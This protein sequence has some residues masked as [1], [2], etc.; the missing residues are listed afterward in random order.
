MK[1]YLNFFFSSFRH[2]VREIQRTQTVKILSNIKIMFCVSL[3][4]LDSPCHFQEKQKQTQVRQVPS[5]LSY[6]I[7]CNVFF[8]PKHLR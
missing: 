5:K 6:M 4:L 1:K 2:M 8:S 7:W 3:S